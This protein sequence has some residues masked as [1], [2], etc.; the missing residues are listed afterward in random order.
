MV[1]TIT[2]VKKKWRARS[3]DRQLAKRLNAL[4]P[5]ERQPVRAYLALNSLDEAF[6]RQLLGTAQFVRPPVRK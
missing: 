6:I 4:P 5:E 2:T 1:W 3:R